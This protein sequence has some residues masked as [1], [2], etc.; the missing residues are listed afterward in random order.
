VDNIKMD[1][2]ERGWYGT[3]R[4]DLA[5][6]RD[7][8]RALV[9]MVMKLLVQLTAVKFL[10]SCTTGGYSRRTQLRDVLPIPFSLT[11]LPY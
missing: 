8:W 5:Q 1:L 6:D 3:D 7:N 9:K 2:R 4:T 11:L 10:T